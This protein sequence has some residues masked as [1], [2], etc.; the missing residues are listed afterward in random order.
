[1]K[2]HQPLYPSFHLLA[3]CFFVILSFC[4]FLVFWS[5]CLASFLYFVCLLDVFS[6]FCLLTR[7]L[8]I[9]LSFYVA[10]FCFCF[11]FVFSRGVFR[12]FALRYC[13]VKRLNNAMGNNDTTMSCEGKR[14]NNKKTPGKKTKNKSFEIVLFCMAFFRLFSLLFRY[15]V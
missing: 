6:L 7:G 2:W 8:F 1:M 13:G 12:D 15:F 14:R 10:S 3:W 9:I 4:F 5:F 11:F